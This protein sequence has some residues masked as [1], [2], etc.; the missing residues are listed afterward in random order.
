[1]RRMMRPIAALVVLSAAGGC[2]SRSDTPVAPDAPPAFSGGYATGGN[3][4]GA[5]ST[6]TT[7]ATTVP[8]DTTFRRGGHATGGN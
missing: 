2:G 6:T 8:R 7:T 3:R 4:G 5:D 1:M